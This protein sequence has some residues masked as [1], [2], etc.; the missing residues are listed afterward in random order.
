[1][2]AP[3]RIPQT[4]TMM[5]AC[6]TLAPGV[7]DEFWPAQERFGPIAAAAPGFRGVLGGPI[8]NSSWL[9]FGGVFATPEDMDQ[10]YH[11]RHHRAVQNKAYET[12][13]NAYYIRKWRLP[14]DG[15]AVTGRVLVETSL[16]RREPLSD[17]EMSS[18]L[19]LLDQALPAYGPRPF[20]TLSGEFEPNPYQ[21]VGPLEEAPQLAPVRYLLLTHWD[22]AEQASKWSAS[23]ELMTL[24]ELGE[25]STRTFIPIY[26]QPGERNYLTPDGMHRQWVRPA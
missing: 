21:F 22:S 25:V 14:E 7:E 16:A 6:F 11:T 18:V 2:A 19:K 5:E 15:E 12:W 10:W 20:E 9:Y 24:G 13:F 3:T 17:N 23:P 1:M 4:L 26:H 8:A